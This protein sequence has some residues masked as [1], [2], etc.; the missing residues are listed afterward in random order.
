MRFFLKK[1]LMTRFRP[2]FDELEARIKKHLNLR[3]VYKLCCDV[4]SGAANSGNTKVDPKVSFTFSIILHAC[5]SQRKVQ[6]SLMER[7]GMRMLDLVPIGHQRH[8]SGS[9]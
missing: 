7:T 4:A 9:D 3:N 8:G 1:G 6:S 5:L 2:L